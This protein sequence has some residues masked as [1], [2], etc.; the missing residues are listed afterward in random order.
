MQYSPDDYFQFTIHTE[1]GAHT[2]CK[3][4]PTMP[5]I[6]WRLNVLCRTST[7]VARRL[8]ARHETLDIVFDCVLMCSRFVFGVFFSFPC[9]RRNFSV[10][11]DS[12]FVCCVFGYQTKLCL[13]L[14]RRSNVHAGTESESGNNRSTAVFNHFI[15]RR[16]S[17]CPF[18]MG[19]PTRNPYIE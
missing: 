15:L 4:R 14:N 5:S 3:T 10:R 8:E 16:S 19:F 12:P 11:R 2:N 7:T 18:H 1:V 9:A 13:P 6:E 17:A